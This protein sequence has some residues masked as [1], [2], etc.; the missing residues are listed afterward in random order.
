[1]DFVHPV[2]SVVPGVQGRVL[3][4]LA[5]TTG[6]LNLRALARLAGVS[7]AQAS[8]VMP[9]LVEL[10]LVERREV[11]PSSQFR[12]VHKHVAAD[13]II[14]L[15]QVRE[16]VL[17]RLAG[18][19]QAMPVPPAGLIVFGS[20]ARGQA[21]R[22]SD[23]DVVIVRPSDVVPDQ[24]AWLEGLDRWHD[25]VRELTGNPVEMLE[26]GA[27]ELVDRPGSDETLWQDILR[28]GV[29]VIGPP[30]AELLESAGG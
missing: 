17:D 1:M 5:R 8:R 19:A 29:V 26:V 13:A 3:A 22:S 15:S 24:V 21:D 11:P 18:L 2:E 6:E 25:A 16:T 12:L 4:V 9:A 14:A 27:G 30:L 7:L 10:G 23:I 20:F 28:E